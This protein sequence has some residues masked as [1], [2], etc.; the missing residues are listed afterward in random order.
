M[1][2]VLLPVLEKMY[3]FYEKPR[4]AERFS[5]YLALLQ[6]SSKEEL[7]LPIMGFNPMAKDHVLRQLEALLHMDAE[8]IAASTV[9]ACNASRQH[10]GSQREIT[11]V[12]NLADDVGGAW[13]NRFS[14][15][16]DSCFKLNPYLR[17]NFC[18]P[19]LWVSENYTPNTI[20]TT[21]NESLH[22]SIY[23]SENDQPVTLMEH[24]VQE[25]FVATN[26]HTTNGTTL[27][28]RDFTQY[29]DFLKTHSASADFS[30]IFSFLYGDQACRNLGMKTH[31]LSIPYGGFRYCRQQS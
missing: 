1:H 17:R 30:I 10:H 31:G 28:V 29:A 13:T 2:F 7:Q 8:G 18:T 6:G 15:D 20:R 23:Q 19:F 14:T 26:V 25:C 21:I 9:D 4:S 16:Y 11:V 24:V 3:A 27:T 5:K 12:L 22:R